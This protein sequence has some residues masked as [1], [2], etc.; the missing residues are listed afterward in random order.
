MD[1]SQDVMLFIAATTPTVL[2]IMPLPGSPAPIGYFYDPNPARDGDGG[3]LAAA[4][5]FFTHQ[6]HQ[7]FHDPCL[8][9]GAYHKARR[10]TA[11]II[12][13]DWLPDH[14]LSMGLD[15]LE[16]SSPPSDVDALGM[17]FMAAYLLAPVPAIPPGLISLSP[18]G[19]DLEGRSLLIN[20]Y[21]GSGGS[22]RA[23]HPAL[24]YFL[25]PSRST[26]LVGASPCPPVSRGRCPRL[27]PKP[28]VQASSLVHSSG[29]GHFPSS[30]GY[31]GPYCGQSGHSPSSSLSSVGLLPHHTQSPTHSKIFCGG[32]S[33]SLD[34]NTSHWGSL[35]SSNASVLSGSIKNASV[36]GP[37]SPFAT[38]SPTGRAPV[39]SLPPPAALPP[40]LISL[41]INRFTYPSIKTL[42]DYLA[43]WDLILYWLRHP[44]VSTACSDAALI[45]DP[46]NALAS[47]FW[48]G[49]IWAALKDGPTRFLFENT[50]STY[51]DK[52]FEMLQVLEDNFH[53]SSISNTFTTLLSLFNDTQSDKEGIHEFCS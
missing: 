36:L 51:Y 2:R 17:S 23:F 47:Q 42:D 21:G 45:T 7:V 41:P 28:N 14:I 34:I 5:S 13:V 39:A 8:D 26:R 29:S 53:P 24:P 4:S 37:C 22:V 46:S 16:P 49:Q 1:P 31:G 44:G 25:V 50:G 15:L 27:N 18:I 32:G 43:M 3:L 38:P 11:T 10:V 9:L 6:G 33:N 30:F 20:R 52:G 35:S 48:E 40:G 12:D 19:G